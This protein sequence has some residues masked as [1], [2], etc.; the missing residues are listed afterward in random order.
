[1]SVNIERPTG[2][3]SYPRCV[4]DV[5]EA[6]ILTITCMDD[7]STVAEIPADGWCSVSVSSDD[8][9]QLLYSLTN[10]RGA[11]LREKADQQIRAYLE[12][13]HAHV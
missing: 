9:G 5:F 2:R 1:M 6:N 8:S 4:A 11:E 7:D 10:P 12:T 3:T 13:T